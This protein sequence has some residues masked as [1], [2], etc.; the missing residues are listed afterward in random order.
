MN[1][2]SKKC[3]TEKRVAVIG[4]GPGGLA[5]A[6]RLSNAGVS[7]EVFEASA[8]LGGLARSIMLWGK[9]VELSAH[10]FRSSDEF[11]NQ[12]WQACSQELKEIT[13]RRGIYD[14]STVIEYPMTPLRIARNLGLTD[15]WRALKSLVYHRATK[16]WNPIANN[17][18]DW[19]VQTYG[20]VLHQRFL[21]DYAEQLWGVPCDQISASFPQFL[22]QSSGDSKGAQT[23]YYPK[24]G[25]S[26]VWE[27]LAERLQAQGVTIH[28][29]TRVSQLDSAGNSISGLFI[30][31]ER[32]AFDH[33][34]STMPLGLLARLALPDNPMVTQAGKALRARST[35]LVYLRAKAGSQSKYNWLSVYPKKYRVGRITDFGHWQESQDG[36]TV[37]CLEYWCDRGDEL[38]S[39]SNDALTQL[40]MSELNQTEQFGRV[41]MLD[42]H[43]ERLPATHPVF[44]LE[45]QEAMHK[46]NTVLSEIKGLSSVGR[47][48]SHGVLGMGESMEAACEVADRVSS[49]LQ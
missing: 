23:F 34:I 49:S 38:W 16:R 43:I 17:A 5:A 20:R 9:P 12:L 22:F 36:S 13:L 42:S 1:P 2:Q 33:V 31:G 19:M 35:V 29:N 47:H 39:K 15:T 46:I 26:S 14:G 6:A 40:A 48:G 45:A 4:A 18:E 41:E 44:S 3:S 7:V 27:K 32:I 8:E 10:I 24:Q 21:K 30:N 11:V 37:Y 28:L 25:N